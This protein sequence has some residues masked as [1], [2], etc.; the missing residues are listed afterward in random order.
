MI[1]GDHQ[2]AAVRQSLDQIHLSGTSPIDRN[3]SEAHL[4]SE[5]YGQMSQTAD[6]VNRH[7]VAGRAPE[8]RSE[9]NVVMP[10]HIIGAASAKDS[11][12]GMCA[13]ASCGATRYSA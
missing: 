9:L 7:R 6:P 5:L 8:C 4:V 2:Q 13:R 12:S 3:S 10:A 1:R 11:A